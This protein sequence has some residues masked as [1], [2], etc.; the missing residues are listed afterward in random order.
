MHFG[1]NILKFSG[2]KIKFS[3]TPWMPIRN[4]FSCRVVEDWNKMP[5]EV[6]KKENSEH[7]LEQI[8]ETQREELVPPI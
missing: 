5:S 7:F 2:K 3:F 6:K 4:F 8:Q 1:Q